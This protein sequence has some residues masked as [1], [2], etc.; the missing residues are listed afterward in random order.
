MT[1]SWNSRNSMD[2]YFCNKNHKWSTK[3]SV[4]IWWLN[5]FKVEFLAFTH[6]S[7]MTYEFQY[8]KTIVKIERLKCKSSESNGKE[9]IYCCSI[10]MTSRFHF[11]VE[12]QCLHTICVC[13]FVCI[14]PYFIICLL[15]LLC[16]V[17]YLYFA[18]W[19]DGR[20]SAMP[21]LLKCLFK[22]ALYS[23]RSSCFDKASFFSFSE[24]TELLIYSKQWGRERP[25]QKTRWF[26]CQKIRRNAHTL[27]QMDH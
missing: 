15:L 6:D 8:N 14:I 17:F 19:L 20:K 2:F 22:A 25:A 10:E 11:S 16:S 5:F 13:L 26:Y 3:E 9:Q 27:T 12:L 24:Q 18:E 1:H 4:L 23:I 21:N 7:L